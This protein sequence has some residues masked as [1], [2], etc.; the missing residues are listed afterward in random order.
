MNDE[1]MTTREWL[2]LI[3]LT[4]SAFLVNTSEFIPVGLLTDIA[5]SLGVTEAKAGILIT[6]YSWTVTLFSLPLMLVFF[7]DEAKKA[8]FA[9]AVRL[10]TGT[11]SFSDCSELR[12]PDDCKNLRGQLALHLLVDCITSGSARGFKEAPFTGPECN[13][14]GDVGCDG[15]RDATWPSDRTS[16]RLED[17]VYVRGVSGGFDSRVSDRSLS[18]SFERCC[19]FS[20]KHS[21]ASE[22]QAPDADICHLCAVGNCLLHRL[23][24]HRAVPAPGC[25][26]SGRDGHHRSDAVWW[27][28]PC[29]QHS[30]LPL[31]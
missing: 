19:I 6:G 25:K 23:R 12:F 8:A 3:G 17:D 16:N 24:L 9:D 22:K 18:G 4:V 21:G 11:V 5:G 27:S 28:G 10:F 13:C 14:H 15:C 26:P 7:P 2:P 31:L 20:Q 1:K 29:R 30:L